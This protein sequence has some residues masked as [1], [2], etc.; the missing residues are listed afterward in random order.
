MAAY[1]SACWW[2]VMAPMAWVSWSAPVD[3]VM[4]TF[5]QLWHRELR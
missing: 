1:Q 5:I 3:A 2:L 4:E